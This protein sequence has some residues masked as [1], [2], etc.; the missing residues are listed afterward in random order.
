MVAETD[1]RYVQWTAVFGGYSGIRPAK[2]LGFS[3]NKHKEVVN[4]R[5]MGTST[6]SM[7]AGTAVKPMTADAAKEIAGQEFA[8]IVESHRP[9]IFRFLLA[10][11]RDRESAENLTQDCFVRAYRARGQFRGGFA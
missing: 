2:R 4:L 10:S 9:Q 1:E 8:R 5:P 6:K 7:A 11:L 3:A